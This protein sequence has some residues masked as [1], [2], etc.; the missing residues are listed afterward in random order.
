MSIPQNGPRRRG[1]K[2]SDNII[3]DDS[4]FDLK[5][6][7]KR[8]DRWAR[9]IV[10]RLLSSIDWGRIDLLEGSERV[11]FGN[12]DKTNEP[13]ATMEVLHPRFYSVVVFGGSVGLAQAYIAGLWNCSD[14]TNVVRIL[15]RNL[16]ALERVEYG[17][18]WTRRLLRKLFHLYHRNTKFGS[19]RNILAH[20]D[21]GNEFYE[22]FLD[23]TMTYSCGI[24][25]SE[26]SSL[27]QASIAKYDRICRKLAL[28]PEDHIIEIG[29]GW[30]GFAIYAAENFKC[31]ITT[32]T[33]SDKQYEY[34]VEAIENKGLNERIKVLKSDYRD[35]SG[36]FDKL[37]SIEMIEAVGHEFMPTFFETCSR[38]LKPEGVMALQAI[39][40]ADQ[41]Y[42]QHVKDVDFIKR[43]IF[44][45]SC[46]T[47][48]TNICSVLSNSTDLRLVHME[49]IT[50]HYTRTLHCW[51]DR[52]RERI[53]EVRHMGLPES[54]VRMWEYYFCYCEGAFEERYIGDVQMI[55]SK[56]LSRQVSILGS[57]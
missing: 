16:P 9:G 26:S 48:V 31:H 11:S 43:Y 57:L 49:D 37:V 56:P 12:A 3:P 55:L 14:L 34:T 21:L 23:K 17:P 36:T 19:R 28:E 8:V 1:K 18:A 27:E 54:F 13:E 38:L 53:D 33:I 40:I 22:L 52:F 47:S 2:M 46:L 20:Y 50:Q 51:R 5:A 7:P 32:T 35:L 6:P 4:T 39:T 29:C 41:R 44:P 15:V 30:G 42:A 45:G 24:F 10:R 25:E